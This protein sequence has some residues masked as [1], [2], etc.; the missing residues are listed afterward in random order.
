MRNVTV[1]G[2]ALAVG[3]LLTGC[4]S[5]Q[6]GYIPQQTTMYSSMDS[7]ALVYTSPATASPLEDHPLRLLAFGMYPAGVAADYAVVRPI[8]TVTSWLPGL[9]GYTGED[10]MIHSQRRTAFRTK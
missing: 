3:L 4:S 1:T 9:F 8:Y 10:A 2:F 6:Q 7:T 5:T